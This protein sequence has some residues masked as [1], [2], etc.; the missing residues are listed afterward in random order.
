MGKDDDPSGTW[1]SHVTVDLLRDRRIQF[2]VHSGFFGE[3]CQF[4]EDGHGGEG[5]KWMGP[6]IYAGGKPGINLDSLMHLGPPV[7]LSDN[8]RGA[9][10]IRLGSRGRVAVRKGWW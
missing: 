5:V 1:I 7:P 2:V 3:R 8:R 6:P 10:H 4:A 9:T